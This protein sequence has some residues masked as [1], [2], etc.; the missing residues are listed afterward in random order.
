M[1]DEI[2]Y[3]FPN[4]KPGQVRTGDQGLTMWIISGYDMSFGSEIVGVK[5]III[6]R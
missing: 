1:W 5:T 4:Y 3:P 6:S 2:T